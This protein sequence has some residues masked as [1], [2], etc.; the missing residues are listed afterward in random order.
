MRKHLVAALVAAGAIAGVA[1]ADYVRVLETYQVKALHS[2]IVGESVTEQ[3]VGTIAAADLTLSDDL[4]VAD[5]ATITDNLVADE[6]RA[7]GVPTTQVIGAGGTIA[8][9]ACGG[10]KKLSSAAAVT[11][12]TTNTITAPAAS[13]KG[14]VM[15]VVNTNASDTITLDDNALFEGSGVA[16]GTPGNTVVGAGDVC[17]VGSDGAVWR[18][19]G[20]CSQG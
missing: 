1:G 6:I 3:V 18:Q 2:V 8:A 15:Y 9:D 14:C 5:D 17:A 16:G 12:D 19:L 13:N 4:T 11:T 20:P 10:F 7:N